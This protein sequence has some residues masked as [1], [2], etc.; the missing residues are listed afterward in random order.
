MREGCGEGGREGGVYGCV[1]AFECSTFP[2]RNDPILAARGGDG[3]RRD[4]AQAA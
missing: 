4:G 3:A 2:H 1:V